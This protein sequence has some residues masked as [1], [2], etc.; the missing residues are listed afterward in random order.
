MH[1]VCIIGSQFSQL[2]LTSLLIN[3]ILCHRF[4]PIVVVIVAAIFVANVI[5]SGALQH[6]DAV[7]T[8]LLI[9]LGVVIYQHPFLPLCPIPPI[10][11]LTLH[12]AHPPSL[13]WHGDAPPPC[14]GIAI[15]FFL[16]VCCVSVWFVRLHA[17]LSQALAFLR[18][19]IAVSS[20]FSTTVAS[21]IVIAVARGQGA[22]PAGAVAL[23]CFAKDDT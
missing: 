3:H 18:S 22:V 5:T 1:S 12:G 19:M 15:P 23:A 2:F 10:H 13:L 14:H 8:V 7:D 20:M 11:A 17:F 6:V 21:A 9:L 16:A 4:Q